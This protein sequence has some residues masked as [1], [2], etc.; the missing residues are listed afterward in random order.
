VAVAIR[1][2]RGGDA[3]AIAEIYR[4][5]CEST[6]VSFENEA[7]SATEMAERIRTMG[8]R[9]PWLVLDDGGTLAGY[10]YASRHR[11]RAAYGWAVDVTVYVAPTHRRRG[12]GRALY[13][14]LL[15]LLRLLGYFKA[16]AVITLP[17][18]S[19]IGLHE[20]VGFE[21]VGVFKGVGYK[22]GAWRDVAHY[23]RA[24]Q[25]EQKD[26]PPPR[27]PSALAGL[28]EYDDAL[29]QGARLYRR[30]T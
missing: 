21:P 13:T 24:L 25:P 2:A 10:A 22:L 12:V 1:P 23:Q 20:A 3:A 7:P 29:A 16:Y 15:E 19:S 8:E 6:T 11:E 26:P 14:S 9:L 4:P 30:G 17:N 28:P 27:L 18:P 5:F